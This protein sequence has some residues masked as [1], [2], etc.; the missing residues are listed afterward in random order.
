[1]N[2]Y[3]GH[4]APG[5]VIAI[6]IVIFFGIFLA[7]GMIFSQGLRTDVLNWWQSLTSTVKDAKASY[8][9]KAPTPEQ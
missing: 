1:M 6:L 8:F 2:R 9:E 5:W 4:T 3:S 7:L